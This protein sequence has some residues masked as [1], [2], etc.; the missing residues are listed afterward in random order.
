MWICA[1][2]FEDDGDEESDGGWQQELQQ[3][4]EQEAQFMAELR[5]RHSEAS[6][7]HPNTLSFAHNQPFGPQPTFEG[8][9]TR[10]VFGQVGPRLQ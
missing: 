4:Y 7:P 10:D 6:L 5:A 1:L 9:A 3:R 8:E 2:D